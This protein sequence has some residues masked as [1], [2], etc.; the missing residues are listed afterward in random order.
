[1]ARGWE[2]KSVESQ[3]ETAESRRAE[4]EIPVTLSPEELRTIREREGLE[5]SIS[6]VRHDLDR[7]TQ[8]KYREQLEAALRHLEEKLALLT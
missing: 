2:S 3:I 1:M 8:P 5:M 6:R 4:R 7:A